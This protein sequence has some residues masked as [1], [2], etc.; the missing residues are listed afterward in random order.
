ML[1]GKCISLQACTAAGHSSIHL[2][3]LGRT[4]EESILSASAQALIALSTGAPL[5]LSEPSSS[6]CF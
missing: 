6:S 3:K 4:Q 5:V 2:R 1:A